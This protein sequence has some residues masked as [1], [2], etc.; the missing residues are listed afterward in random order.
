MLIICN[1]YFVDILT[2]IEPLS[3]GNLLAV[4]M[5]KIYTQKLRPEVAE[6]IKE[7]MRR[8]WAV[9]DRIFQ[10]KKITH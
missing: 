10:F 1:L 3:W 9:N 8:I 4:K 2:K 6:A 7:K 5:Y